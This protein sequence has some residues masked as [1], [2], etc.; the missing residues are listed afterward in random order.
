[1][2]SP[3][4]GRSKLEDQIDCNVCSKPI[5]S[6]QMK[7]HMKSHIPWMKERMQENQSIIHRS[8]RAK[9]HD[10]MSFFEKNYPW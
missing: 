5:A 8:L 2:N 10:K 4:K 1:M 9:A 6:S 3:D 7:N